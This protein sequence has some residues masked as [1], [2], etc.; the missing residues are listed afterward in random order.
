VLFTTGFGPRQTRPE[1]DTVIAF[2]L[3]SGVSENTFVPTPTT[4]SGCRAVDGTVSRW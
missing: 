2:W 1:F 3:V 4:C